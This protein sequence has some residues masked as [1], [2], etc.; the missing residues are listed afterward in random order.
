MSPDVAALVSGAMVMAY[1]VAALFFARFWRD[2]R[3]RLF[4]FFTAAFLL[5]AVQRLLLALV[6]DF[7]ELSLLAYGLRLFGFLL[8]LTAVLDK[9]RRR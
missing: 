5:F 8:I 6:H 1:L 3:D 7:G 9:N 4:A 2:T